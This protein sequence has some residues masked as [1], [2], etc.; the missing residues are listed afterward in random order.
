MFRKFLFSV[1][2]L[3]FA[4]CMDGDLQKTDTDAIILKKLTAFLKREGRPEN[5][6]SPLLCVVCFEGVA[7]LLK[8]SQRDAFIDLFNTRDLTGSYED[9]V[10]N[11]MY[12]IDKILFKLKSE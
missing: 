9:Y 6:V 7:E 5:G 2:A 12:E 4:Y 10:R 11:T 3:N 8:T 1:F